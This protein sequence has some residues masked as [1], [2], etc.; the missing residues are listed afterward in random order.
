MSSPLPAPRSPLPAP[1]RW[2]I[3]LALLFLSATGGAWAWYHVAPKQ[4]P[5]S[6]HFDATNVVSGWRFRAEPVAEQAM[7][8]LATTNLFNGTFFNEEGERVTVF[9]GTWDAGNPKQ[10]SVVGHTPDV[11]WVGAGW[12]PVRAEHPDKLPLHFG[13]DTIPF[14]ART[15]LTPDGR[16]RELTVWCTLVSGQVFEETSRFELGAEANG[17]SRKVLQ[18]AG[19]RH[20]LKSKFLKAITDRIPGEGTKQFVRFSTSFGSDGQAAFTRLDE[21]GRRWLQLQAKV[22]LSDLRQP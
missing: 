6:Y 8:I 3:L 1:V 15:F 16:Q 20:A 2:V 19:A 4:F 11:C 9:M 5:V 10:L 22:N 7:E 21:F 12:K 13:P 17:S 18:D 14:E